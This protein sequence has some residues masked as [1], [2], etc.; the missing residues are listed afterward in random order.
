VFAIPWSM[1]CF[2]RPNRRWWAQRW[3]SDEAIARP[4]SND[5]GGQREPA[6][7]PER[8]NC[9]D[10]KSERFRAVLGVSA[11]KVQRSQA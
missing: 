4:R 1:P 9:L 10:W 7:D 5:L 6:G 11:M 8:A 2:V 3:P